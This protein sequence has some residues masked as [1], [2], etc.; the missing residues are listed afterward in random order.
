MQN[1][2]INKQKSIERSSSEYLVN[3]FCTVISML[4]WAHI[5][6]VMIP[7]F[8]IIK[9]L[10][11]KLSAGM[12]LTRLIVAV[13]V[14]LRVIVN[15]KIIHYKSAADA[16]RRQQAMWCSGV[17]KLHH[18]RGLPCH[19]LASIASTP[20]RSLA[21]PPR[22]A[23]WNTATGESRVV[24]YVTASRTTFRSTQPPVPSR[25]KWKS[26]QYSSVYMSCNIN[27]KK[28]YIFMAILI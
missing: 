4:K 22:L 20:H 27:Y 12:R 5:K 14:S 2:E 1:K 24:T 15:R 19:T 11:R 25:T 3:E 18:P 17:V 21:W 26:S 28:I 6:F 7:P 8:P 13:I 10:H 23:G 9:Y 16:A